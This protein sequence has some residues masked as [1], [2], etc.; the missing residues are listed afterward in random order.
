M[1]RQTKEKHDTAAMAKGLRELFARWAE[2]EA[3]GTFDDEPTWEEVKA[4]LD[5]EREYDAGKLFPQG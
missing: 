2:E 5:R 4:A 3:E 1:N